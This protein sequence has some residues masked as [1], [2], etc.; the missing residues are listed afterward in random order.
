MVRHDHRGPVERLGEAPLEPSG[1]LFEEAQ[2]VAGGQRYPGWAVP[3]HTDHPVVVHAALGRRHRLFL[4]V[5][6]EQ[7]E[8]RPW[9]RTEEAH[10]AE[11]N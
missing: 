1:G 2:G 11:F 6:T 7:H 4:T 9:R 10:P 3:S 8:I 5:L